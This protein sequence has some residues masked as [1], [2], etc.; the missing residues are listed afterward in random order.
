VVARS[1][2]IYSEDFRAWYAAY[3]RK[4]SPGDAWRAWQ[5]VIE[6]PTL[7]ELLAALDWQKKTDQWTRDAG[8][9]IPYPG[10]YLRGRA[11]EDDPPSAGP[12]CAWHRTRRND[13]HRNPGETKAGCPECRHLEAAAGKRSGDPVPVSELVDS[14]PPPRPDRRDSPELRADFA[15]LFPGEAWPGFAA[16]FRAVAEKMKP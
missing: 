8:R 16:A 3:P 11:F 5:S 7:P 13:G 15:R 6:R 10:T 4:R 2:P 14:L 9:W 1:R 12:Y